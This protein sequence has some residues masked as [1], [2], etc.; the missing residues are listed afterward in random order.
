MISHPAF[1]Y[2][3]KDYEIDQIPIEYEGKDPTL[4]KLSETFQEAKEKNIKKVFVQA[5]YNNKGAEFIAEKMELPL[6]WVDPYSINYEENLK[7]FVEM[8]ISK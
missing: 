2:F 4:K 6:R 8:L 7:N 3:C 1:G 5:Q